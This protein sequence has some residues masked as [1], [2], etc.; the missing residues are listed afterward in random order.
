MLPYGGEPYTVPLVLKENTWPLRAVAVNDT[1]VSDELSATYTISMPSPGM[2]YPSLAA[3]TYTQRQRVRIFQNIERTRDPNVTI[4]YTIDGS[5][6][7]ADSPIYDQDAAK[8]ILLPGGRVTL[9]AVAVNEYGK[10]SNTLSVGY[11]IEAKPYPLDS[12]TYEDTANGLRLNGTNLTDFTNAYGQPQSQ[13]EIVRSNF[14]GK[15]TKYTYS[16]GY[17]VF[18]NLK[19]VS[20]LIELYF[21]G[22][23]FKGPR[24]T[25]IGASLDQVVGKFRDMG[26]PESPSGNRGLYSNGDGTGRIYVNGNGTRR[27]G[28]ETIIYPQHPVKA[29]VVRYT[30]RTLDSHTWSLD[31]IFDTSDRVAAIDMLYIP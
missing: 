7:D 26:Q 14:S 16:W 24:G 15:V 20:S 9:K 27:V 23:T 11:K 28:E 4:Y 22:S 2:P 19:G 29:H 30:C 10:A 17:A 6:P 18:H 12:Y 25:G 31:Y 3:N 8:G 1:L 13:E 5:E 21:T